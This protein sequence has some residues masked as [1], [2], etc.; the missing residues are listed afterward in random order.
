MLTDGPHLACARSRR[1][2]DDVINVIAYDPKEFANAVRAKTYCAGVRVP[3]T[4]RLQL[5]LSSE[6]P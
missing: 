1:D 4:D 6:A 5:T 3:S 2:G